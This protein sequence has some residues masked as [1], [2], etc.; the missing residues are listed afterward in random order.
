MRF[1]SCAPWQEH[2]RLPAYAAPKG[3]VTANGLNPGYF[4]DGLNRPTKMLYASSPDRGLWQLLS[5]WPIIKQHAPDAL[6]DV[7]YGFNKLF[8]RR[9]G[10]DVVNTFMEK[11]SQPG[12]TFHGMVR[13]ARLGAPIGLRRRS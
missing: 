6:L 9:H 8:I 13:A 10:E 2:S 12:I 5:V 1:C 7:Y 4:R 11:L 3:V